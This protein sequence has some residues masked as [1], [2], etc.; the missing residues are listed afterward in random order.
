MTS[1][2]EFMTKLDTLIDASIPIIVTRTREPQLVLTCLNDWVS[3]RNQTRYQQFLVS[4]DRKD[5]IFKGPQFSNWNIIRG[6]SH[7]MGSDFLAELEDPDHLGKHVA[8]DPTTV[9]PINALSAIAGLMVPNPEDSPYGDGI[10]AMQWPHCVFKLPMLSATLHD[11]AYRLISDGKKLILILPETENV[12]AELH[13]FVAYLDFNPPTKSERDTILTDTLEAFDLAG[14][15]NLSEADRDRILSAGAGMT[16]YELNNALSRAV[17]SLKTPEAMTSEAISDIVLNLKTEM[18]KRSEVLEVMPSSSMSEI[19]GLDNLKEQITEWSHCFSEEAKEFGVD[20]PKG[21]GLFGPPGTGKSMCAKAIG[22]TLGLPVIRFDVSRV[23]NSLVG[24]SEERIRSALKL[25]EAMS[26]CVAFLDEVDKAF[27]QNS[28]GGDSGVGSRVLGTLLTFLQETDAP[29][30]W[31]FTGNSVDGLPPEMLRKGRL[32]EIFSVTV[33]NV[34]ER[35]EI[36]AIHLRKRKQDPSQIPN[37]HLAAEGAEGYVAAELESAVKQAIVKAYVGKI[38]LTGELILKQLKS[39]APLSE[40][41][42][43]KFEA[44]RSWAENNARPA[45]KEISS[46]AFEV[47]E[48]LPIGKKGLRRTV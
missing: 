35:A 31:V 21:I 19:G 42:Q 11:Y 26:P 6:W 30:F 27:N 33:P 7:K 32:D 45:S 5:T 34:V 9:E 4:E 3:A 25:V 23:F 28:G 16:E 17:V 2:L 36:F 38:E 18:V 10:Y 43:A 22:H 44:M 29:I 8:G 39:S 41:F 12:P 46:P 47:G 40:A 20:T 48:P 37:L 24:S 1:R 13:D 15:V 14:K